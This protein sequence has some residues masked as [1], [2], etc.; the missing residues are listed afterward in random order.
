M[1]DATQIIESEP[2]IQRRRMKDMTKTMCAPDGCLLLTPVDTAS[3]RQYQEQPISYFLSRFKQI[4]N[5]RG[6]G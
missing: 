2:G 5:A 6:H 4:V 3:H 1:V